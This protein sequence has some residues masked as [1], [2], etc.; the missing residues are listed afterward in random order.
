MPEKQFTTTKDI[1]GVF[2]PETE[3]ACCK[4]CLG[5]AALIVANGDDND[6]I[7]PENIMARPDIFCH[8]CQK[9]I[10]RSL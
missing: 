3:K 8:A 4:T 7:T 2:F 9:Q 10:K 5:S 1:L 6:P